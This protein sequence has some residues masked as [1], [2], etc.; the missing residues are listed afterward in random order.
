MYQWWSKSYPSTKNVYVVQG[1]EAVL[2]CG[3]GSNRLVWRVYSG[4][5]TNIVANDGLT[6]DDPEY[7]TFKNPS[8]GRYYRLHM[9]NVEVSNLKKNR[10]SGLV[11]GVNRIF[12]LKLDLLGMCNYILVIFKV[13]HILYFR[14]SF[15]NYE[16]N[17][18]TR[19][20]C[21]ISRFRCRSMLKIMSF[22]YW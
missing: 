12:F 5:D 3:F 7:S 18:V 4:G 13:R 17:G 9:L 1:G 8:T 10:C 21:R 16:Y 20:V 19:K 2:Q 6:I 15:V 14:W 22:C 11:N